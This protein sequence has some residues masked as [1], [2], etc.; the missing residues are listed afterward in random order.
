MTVGFD[1][2]HSLVD[3]YS[4]LAYSPDLPDEKRPTCAPVRSRAI[5]YFAARGIGRIESLLTDNAWAYRRS[6]RDVCARHGIRQRFS[7]PPCPW[8]NGKAERLNRTLQTEWDYRQ[9]FDSNDQ[10][11]QAL[12]PWLEHYNTQRSHSALGGHPPVSRLLPT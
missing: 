5:G 12:A 8:Q 10:R 9:P 11:A 1:Y 2:V 6:L 4:P 7:K 3:D